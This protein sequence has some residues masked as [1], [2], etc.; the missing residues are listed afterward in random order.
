MSIHLH[1]RHKIHVYTSTHAY[2]EFAEKF[3]GLV[4]RDWSLNFESTSV[5]V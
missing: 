5:L 2:G 3:L 4:P 1:M